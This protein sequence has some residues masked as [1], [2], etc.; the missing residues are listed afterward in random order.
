MDECNTILS[1]YKNT[2]DSVALIHRYVIS[3]FGALRVKL[4][5]ATSWPFDDRIDQ[6]QTAQNVQSDL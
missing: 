4:I 2:W 6:N 1:A 3:S 5:G